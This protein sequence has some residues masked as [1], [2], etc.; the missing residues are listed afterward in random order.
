MKWELKG[1]GK[2][3]SFF[4][5]FTV[6]REERTVIQLGGGDVDYFLSQVKYGLVAGLKKFH[7]KSSIGSFVW[8]SWK[9]WKTIALRVMS[10][11]TKFI[12]CLTQRLRKD[13]TEN[14]TLRINMTKCCTRFEIYNSTWH[15]ASSTI[16]QA[17]QRGTMLLVYTEGRGCQTA[18]LCEE[19]KHFK[20]HPTPCLT[21]C[22]TVFPRGI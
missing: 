21:D 8:R 16:C 3:I 12:S 19:S 13:R 4:R 18:A 15:L 11:A 6:S 7:W 22:W 5:A 17:R 10:S 1:A 9:R 14:E 2:W 20:E